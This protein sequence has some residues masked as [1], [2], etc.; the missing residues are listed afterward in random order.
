MRAKQS[1]FES[2]SEYLSLLGYGGIQFKVVILAGED[3]IQLVCSEWPTSIP[4]R[5][6]PV[7]EGPP[8]RALWLSPLEARM[9]GGLQ[10]KG[11]M[12]TAALAGA[13]GEEPT[14]E[15]RCILR[16]LGER[17]IVEMSHKSGVRLAEP[18]VPHM[19]QTEAG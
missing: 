5:G 17:G 1:M 14:S 15:F 4:T 13:V 12:T 9:V 3:K 2:V 8:E 7:R 18:G 16:N 11:W 10:G 6:P 19:P